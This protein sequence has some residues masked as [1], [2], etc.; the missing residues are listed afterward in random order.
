M[1][2]SARHFQSP[3]FVKRF[4]DQLALLK[5]NTLHWHLTD[6]QGWRIEIKRYPK[7][8]SIG[9]W[10]RPAGA[11]GTDASRQAGALRRLLHAGRNPRHRALR[12]PSA[13]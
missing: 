9:A 7:L 11:A 13:T 5:L 2:D 3:A 1:L 4:I 10:R 8:T 6:D 12:E